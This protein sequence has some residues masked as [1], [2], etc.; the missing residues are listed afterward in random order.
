MRLEQIPASN[1]RFNPVYH[2]RHFSSHWDRNGIQFKRRIHRKRAQRLLLFSEKTSFMVCSGNGTAFA[3]KE[4]RLSQAASIHLSHHDIHIPVINN[5]NVSRI[6]QKSRWGSSVVNIRRFFISA[7]RASKIYTRSIYCQI[8]SQT[9][10]QI[11][12]FCLRLFT[13]F[14]RIRF[15]FYPH[16][17]STGFWD[18]HN[19]LRG[20]IYNAIYRWAQK[21]VST[22]FYCGNSSYYSFGNYDRGISEKQNYGLSQS[23]GGSIWKSISSH[24]IFLCIWKRRLL[25][26]GFRAKF[27]KAFSPT[28]SAHGFYFFSDRGRAGICGNHHNRYFIF[29]IYLEGFSNSLP[30]QGPFWNSSSNWT[31]SVNR[32]TGF[33]KFGSGFRPSPHQGI[34]LAFYQHGWIL[35]V[36]DD[37]FSGRFTKYFKAS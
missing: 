27:S 20:H 3:Y 29:N 12:K 19:H 1:L 37:V 5:S 23:L 36:G 16:F 2:R 4:Y 6:Q 26:N 33:Y 28:G 21:K 17:I 22:S 25:G 24:S 34:D 10:G 30:S 18:R 13:Q 32:F 35:N 11:K 15:L 8:F 31:D 9:S 14:D 7:V